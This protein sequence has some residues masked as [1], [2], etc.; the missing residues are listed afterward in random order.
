VLYWRQESF[1][2]Q[3]WMMPDS[4]KALIL[5]M[6]QLGEWVLS[7]EVALPGAR[8]VLITSDRPG[9]VRNADFL[10]LRSETGWRRELKRELAGVTHVIALA[11]VEEWQRGGGTALAAEVGKVSSELSALILMADPMRPGSAN[12][13][14]LAAELV[15]FAKGCFDV[16][17]WDQLPPSEQLKVTPIQEL[18]AQRGHRAARLLEHLTAFC[19]QEGALPTQPADLKWAAEGSRIM[20]AGLS[21]E[22]AG[23]A[24]KAAR[25]AVADLARRSLSISRSRMML[26]LLLARTASLGQTDQAVRQAAEPLG[27]NHS[28]LLVGVNTLAKSEAPRAC[29]FAPMTRKALT[30][31]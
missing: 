24:S 29:I 25:S 18:F 13:E 16:V 26:H 5:A 28:D 10:L 12:L 31:R 11:G 3:A 21:D 19:S 4:K 15:E 17:I 23:D 22:E 7:N 2:G 14:G 6:E 8:S 9:L 1:S 30:A 27:L 20:L